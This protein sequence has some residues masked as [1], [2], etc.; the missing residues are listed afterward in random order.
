[1]TVM[2]NF[3]SQQAGAKEPAWK[4]DCGVTD[5]AEDIIKTA[6]N[7]VDDLARLRL[8]NQADF[9]NLRCDSNDQIYNATLTNLNWKGVFLG[10]Y[11]VAMWCGKTGTLCCWKSLGMI[12]PEG[13]QEGPASWTSC[14]AQND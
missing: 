1:M 7:K 6:W 9:L 14:N 12:I 4:N 11:E 8:T 13:A 3:F 2:L 5:S 10:Y